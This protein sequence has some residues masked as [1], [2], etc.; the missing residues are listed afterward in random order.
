MFTRLKYDNDTYQD[1]LKRSTRAV[2]HTMDPNWNTN[3]GTCYSNNGKTSSRVS[4]NDMIDVDSILKGIY[5]KKSNSIRGQHATPINHTLYMPP[6]CDSRVDT[7]YSRYSHPSYEIR[8]RAIGDMHMEYPL[9]DPQ[10]NVFQNFEVNTRLHSKDN[11]RTIWQTPINQENF[12][13][14]EIKE[15]NN[16]K[17]RCEYV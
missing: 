11:H 15:T 7:S 3:C 10:C 14:R 8:G 13:P 2:L 4:N 12:L 1:D 6:D 16:R 5:D 9:F 17:I